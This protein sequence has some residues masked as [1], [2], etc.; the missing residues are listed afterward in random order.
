LLAEQANLEMSLVSLTSSYDPVAGIAAKSA[1][2]STCYKS[3]WTD[4]SL[5]SACFQM[6]PCLADRGST[7]AVVC[8]S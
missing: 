5:W 2:N 6:P 8:D 4:L 1:Q 7:S 3:H